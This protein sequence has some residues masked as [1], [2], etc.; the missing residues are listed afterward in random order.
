MKKTIVFAFAA[1]ALVLMAGCQKDLSSA[2][3]RDVQ[4]SK[5]GN[6]TIWV[7]NIP[8]SGWNE[9]PP[10][11]LGDTGVAILRLTA[12]SVLHSKVKVELSAAS[13]LLTAAHIHE[14]AAG[15]NGQVR[16]GLASSA[17]DFGVF[18]EI[19]LTAVQ[20]DLLF[21]ESK[22]L[23]V[24]AHTTVKPGGLVRGQIR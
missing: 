11:A 14:A 2:A 20:Y 4:L 10:N 22:P 13:G 3:E 18:R 9:V 16:I 1:S 21:D 17:A 15:A 8:L 23:Y 5:S 6:A 19:K 24:N 7:R 12:D